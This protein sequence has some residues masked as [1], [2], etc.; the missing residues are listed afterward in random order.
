MSAA[1]ALTA[2]MAVGCEMGEGDE[3]TDSKYAGDWSFSVRRFCGAN[4]AD[5]VTVG[6][7]GDFEFEFSLSKVTLSGTGRIG[8]SGAVT[9]EYTRNDD[10]GA[11]SGECDSDTHCVGE[12]SNPC[13]GA[14]ELRKK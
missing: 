5:S 10:S 1:L 9:G 11:L 14:W 4:S 12:F 13:P 3:E 6:D 2:L 7:D 8:E